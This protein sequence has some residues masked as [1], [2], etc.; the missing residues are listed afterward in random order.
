MEMTVYLLFIMAGLLVGGTYS[1][2][3]AG[4]R[5]WT[6]VLGLLAVIATAGA[7]MWLIGAME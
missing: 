2:Y 7:V 6:I 4:S 1:A 5:L 3:S